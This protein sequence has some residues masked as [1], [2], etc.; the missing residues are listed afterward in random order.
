MTVNEGTTTYKNDYYQQDTRMAI[1]FG[2]AIFAATAVISISAYLGTGNL[3]A[4]L[5]VA[6]GSLS[7]FS[8]YY[9]RTSVTP[10]EVELH[11]SGVQF[12]YRHRR[13]TLNFAWSD[14]RKIMAKE[15][16]G[17]PT[18]PRR[19][20]ALT[21]HDVSGKRNVFPIDISA[22]LLPILRAHSAERNKFLEWKV[23]ERRQRSA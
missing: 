18:I 22:A 6:I 23:I 13:K 3:T 1:F 11:E 21:I 5:A 7:A 20:Y 17:E 19:C 12:R 8:A 9:F 15:E 14:I 2:I 16:I 4:F 10:V